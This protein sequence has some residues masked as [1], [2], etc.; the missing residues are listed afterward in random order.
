MWHYNIFNK[1]NII[2]KSETDEKKFS[3]FFTLS[4]CLSP[5]CQLQREMKYTAIPIS[6]PKIPA[7]EF[8]IDPHKWVNLRDRCALSVWTDDFSAWSQRQRE[9]E[10]GREGPLE[11]SLRES[12]RDTNIPHSFRN[13]VKKDTPEFQRKSP[14]KVEIICSPCLKG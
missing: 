5:P 6:I 10:K 14:R 9:R 3:P 1:Q 4:C 7:A 8:W 12:V 11:W 2:H 13:R